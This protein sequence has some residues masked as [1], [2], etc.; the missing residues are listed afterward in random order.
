MITTSSTSSQP[1]GIRPMSVLMRPRSSTAR[2]STTVEAVA[3]VNPNRTAS[4]SPSLMKRP[5]AEPRT[6]A[7]VI[8]AIAPGRAMRCT[9]RRTEEAWPHLLAHLDGCVSGGDTGTA[10][11][12]ARF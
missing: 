3:S 2:S 12:P 8:C 10:R 11:R 4:L 1:T 5:T 9:L 7:A 6:V